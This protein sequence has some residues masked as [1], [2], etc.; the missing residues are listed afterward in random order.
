MTVVTHAAPRLERCDVMGLAARLHYVL[1]QQA[2]A[3]R[4]VR[5]ARIGHR[6]CRWW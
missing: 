2:R 4:L 3:D 5:A 6:V 1:G